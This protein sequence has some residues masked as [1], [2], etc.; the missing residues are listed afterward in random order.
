MV[1]WSANDTWLKGLVY[2]AVSFMV[3]GTSA[4]ALFCLANA[5]PD[6]R[7]VTGVAGWWV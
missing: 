4:A 5:S 3:P 2:N 6:M 7:C 1:A